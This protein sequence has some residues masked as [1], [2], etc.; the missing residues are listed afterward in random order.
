MAILALIRE[1][2]AARS[3][4]RQTFDNATDGAGDLPAEPVLECA[5]VHGGRNAVPR[6]D[7][8]LRGGYVGMARFISQHPNPWGWNPLPYCGLP[9]QFMYVP[10]LPYLSAL[11]IRLLPQA[12]HP[13]VCSARLS[14]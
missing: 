13:I 1:R 14:D 8:M 3:D 4:T 9:T 6:V 2:D 11:F 7:I 12:S 10:N 5:V